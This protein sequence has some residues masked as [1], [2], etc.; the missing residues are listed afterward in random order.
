M[1]NARDIALGC[2]EY[3]DDGDGYFKDSRRARDAFRTVL[4]ALESDNEQTSEE[5]HE[6]T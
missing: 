3:I 6:E 2:I 1:D 5:G 4:D